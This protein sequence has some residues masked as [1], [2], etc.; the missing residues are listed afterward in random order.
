MIARLLI[1]L[2]WL[3]C[4]LFLTAQSKLFEKSEAYL[5]R[6]DIVYLDPDYNGFNGFP[7]G[8]GDMGG[9]LWLSKTG[10]DIQI[11][12]IDLYDVPK[13]GAM[14]LRSAGRVHLDFGIPCFDYLYLK[15]FQARLSLQDALSTI[16]SNTPF[17]N[18]K[19]E[20][21]VNKK[22]NLWILDCSIDNNNSSRLICLDINLLSLIIHNILLPLYHLVVKNN[23]H[24][25]SSML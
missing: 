14:T 22:S 24:L 8:N 12:K 18:L 11:N 2:I 6:H 9:M 5:S 15:D 17:S 7:L 25:K 3:F 13:D 20:S 1:S 23:Q 16:S 4:Q 21:W 10:I 19:I